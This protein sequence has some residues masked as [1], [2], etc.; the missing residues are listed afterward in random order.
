MKTSITNIIKFYINGFR[1]MSKLGRK[2][3]LIIAIKLFIFFVVI[4][5]LFFPD[6]LHEKFHSDK[7]RGD[8]VM[9]NLLGGEK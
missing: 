3:W 7:E 4:K 1:N 9:K 8:Y 2:L 5:M 6:I